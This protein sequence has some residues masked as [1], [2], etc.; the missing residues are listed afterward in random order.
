MIP[1]AVPLALLLAA[2]PAAAGAA[3]ARQWLA[4]LAGRELALEAGT[5]DYHGLRLENASARVAASGAGLQLEP[6]AATLGGGRLRA[7]LR[8]AP[9]GESLRWRLR[10]DA[11]A[12]PYES[13]PGLGAEL[14]AGRLSAAARLA[15]RGRG[16]DALLRD[17]RGEL[18]FQGGPGRLR[19][20]RLDA[21]GE[22]VLLR[23]IGFINPF[24]R[25]RAGS[26]LRC[27]AGLGRVAGGRVRFEDGLA[28]ETGEILVAGGGT[29][30]LEDLGLALALRPRPRQGV[31]LSASVLASLVEVSGT[32]R[33]PQIRPNPPGLLRGGIRIGAGIATT[34]LSRLAGVVLDRPAAGTCAPLV[35]RFPIGLVAPAGEGP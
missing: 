16:L 35:Q 9:A 3:D 5:I 33:A 11:E 12:I 28:L 31:V 10:L 22:D 2:A 23:L 21:A 8:V 20:P 14:R 30:T 7:A 18:V 24:D 6:A 15:G 17:M 32:L 19:D 25:E 29:L 13:V 26:E 4:A 27:L 34:G 1:A